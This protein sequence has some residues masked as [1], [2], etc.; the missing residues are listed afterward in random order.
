MK[1]LKR[2]IV[3]KLGKLNECG[4][5]GYYGYHSSSSSGGSCGGG[6]SSE[7]SLKSQA[8]SAK[9]RNSSASKANSSAT[10]KN[11]T[12]DIYGHT[13]SLQASIDAI[14]TKSSQL[15]KRMPTE[16]KKAID[17]LKAAAERYQKLVDFYSEM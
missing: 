15:G 3:E 7:P 2:A 6:Y 9:K 8:S 4:G 17:E 10:I 16:F 5:G 13:V 1:S 14:T 11:L 12:A